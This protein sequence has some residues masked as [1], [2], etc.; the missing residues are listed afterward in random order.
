M[1]SLVVED[2]TVDFPIYG[3]QK[4]FRSELVARA[5]GG[6]IRRDGRHRG[7]VA[8][9]ALENLS[10]KLGHG[11]RLGIL[12]PNGAGKS[13]LLRVLAGVYVPAPGREIIEARAPAV[14]NA[15]P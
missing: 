6:F 5:T 2:V 8:V 7:R 11:D 4:S 1:A 15:R 10:L 14:F 13:T 12:G 3:S 9:R